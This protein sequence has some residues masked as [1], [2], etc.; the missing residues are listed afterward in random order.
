MQ[1]QI[2]LAFFVTGAVF[3]CDSA[4]AEPNGYKFSE[5]IH[6]DLPEFT[7]TLIPAQSAEDSPTTIT[8]IA[9]A[10][11]GKEIQTI[12]DFSATPLIDVEKNVLEGFVVEDLNFD[13]YKDL[14]LIEFLPAGPNV[15]YLVWFYDAG[16]NRFIATNLFADIPSPEVDVLNRQIVSRWRN[17]AAEHGVSYYKYE[18]SR[19]I[20]VRETSQTHVD[21]SRFRLVV[22][23]LQNGVMVEVKNELVDIGPL[24][25]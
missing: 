15:P 2:I 14:R 25:D 6:A 16:Q 24:D 1:R 8:T 10:A 3:A 4:R 19:L 12:A 20:L 9:V 11:D 17:G 13:G 21:E 5:R 23:E 18:N 22:R 7:F